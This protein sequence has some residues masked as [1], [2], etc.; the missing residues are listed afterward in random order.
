MEKRMNINNDAQ[1]MYN[2]LHVAEQ[3]EKKPKKNSGSNGYFEGRQVKA[4]QETLNLV[5]A[6]SQSDVVTEEKKVE[7]VKRP[8]LKQA[9]E[10]VEKFF[11]I[12]KKSSHQENLNHDSSARSFEKLAERYNREYAKQPMVKVNDYLVGQNFTN[13]HAPKNT[14]IKVDGKYMHANKVFDNYIATQAPLMTN[15]GGVNAK[16]D[17][18]DANRI[19]AFY[20]MLWDNSTDTV[21]N[22]TNEKDKLPKYYPSVPS[23]KS[24]PRS[25]G[26]NPTMRMAV[27]SVK[28]LNDNGDTV[29]TL[30]LYDK[31]KVRSVKVYNYV[32]WPD[33]G[34]PSINDTKNFDQFVDHVS[35]EGTGKSRT[36]V[37]CRAG[38]GR[39]GTFIVYNELKKRIQSGNITKDNL[40][41]TVDNLILTARAQR[42][43]FVV[44]TSQQYEFILNL[45]KKELANYEEQNYEEQARDDFFKRAGSIKNLKDLKKLASACK[46]NLEN[47]PSKYEDSLIGVLSKLPTKEL[48]KIMTDKPFSDTSFF[49][50]T[51]TY[52][53]ADNKMT[54]EWIKKMTP[55]KM[56]SHVKEKYP[57]GSEMSKYFTDLIQEKYFS[58]R[59]WNEIRKK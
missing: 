19:S 38:V 9:K 46:I 22:L 31:H 43:E 20:Q 12:S 25:C 23:G 15:K 50:R 44:Q 45:G 48:K 49:K 27:D 29:T 36:V 4:S 41:E 18:A 37:H 32:N 6:L 17:V 51:A 11:P 30:K 28:Q 1:T 16:D 14:A 34:A 42:G 35:K 2:L 56:K 53:Y 59:T 55:T 21:V 33:H 26:S 47:L 24:L 57:S 13:I 10:M 40:K 5:R 39:T 52:V 54:K 3:S 7:L 58:P 8:T